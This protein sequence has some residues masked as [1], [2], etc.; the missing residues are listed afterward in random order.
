MVVIQSAALQQGRAAGE[1][2]AIVDV[3]SSFSL[4]GQSLVLEMTCPQS[5]HF[6]PQ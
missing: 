4:T 1:V 2:A 5:S 6:L 3:H